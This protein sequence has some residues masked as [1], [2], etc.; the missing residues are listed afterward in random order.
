MLKVRTK[1]DFLK[2][3]ILSGRITESDVTSVVDC[4]KNKNHSNKN[5]VTTP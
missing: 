5:I 1:K 4:L 2:D 3:F